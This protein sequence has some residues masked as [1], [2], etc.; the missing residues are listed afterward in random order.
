MSSLKIL[1]LVIL[2]VLA[3]FANIPWQNKSKIKKITIVYTSNTNGIIEN[4]GCP[5]NP[6]GGLDKRQTIF[7]KLITENKNIL[8]LDAGDMLSSIGFAEK[9]KFVVKAYEAMPYDAI[10]LGDQEFSN[11]IEFFESEVK[12]KLGKKI[13]S[14]N[15]RYSHSGKNIAQE[16]IVKEISGVKIGIT[17]VVIEDPFMLMDEEKVKDVKVEDYKTALRK[18][19]NALKD[20][21]DIIILLS[22]LGYIRDTGLPNEFPEIDVIIGSHSQTL[23]TEPERYGKT[24]VAQAG[25][26]GEHVGCL[27]I[28]FDLGSKKIVSFSNKF[29][30]LFKEIKGDSKIGQIIKEYIKFVSSGFKDTCIYSTPIP[31]EYIVVDNKTCMSCHEEETYKWMITRHAHAYRTIVLDGRTMDPECL[32]CHT[33]GYCTPNGFTRNPFKREF[34]NIGCVECHFVKAEHLE[35]GS[36]EYVKSVTSDICVRCH[37]DFRDP[38]FDFDKYVVKVNHKESEI[39]EYVVSESDYLIKISEKIYGIWWLWRVIWEIN[40]SEIKDPNLIYPGQKFKVVIPDTSVVK[41]KFYGMGK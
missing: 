38:F 7:Q 10:G 9:D 8:F 40:K 12:N 37:N 29:Y 23:L 27:E 39:K 25:K 28:E 13:I 35:T 41:V 34:V 15:L 18:V 1:T 11:G 17:S 33:T 26:N 22:H 14:A 2:G 19:I 31:S 20:K 4:C 6:L 3:F 16:Y 32:S 21:V 5:G 36:S 24:I 30:P